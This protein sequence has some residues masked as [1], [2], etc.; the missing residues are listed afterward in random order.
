MVRVPVALRIAAVALL[1]ACS[2]R[3][4]F[5]MT[6]AVPSASERMEPQHG[7]CAVQR[8]AD[9]RPPRLYSVQGRA[10]LLYL[11]LVPWAS[12]PYERLDWSAAVQGSGG[13][14]DAAPTPAYAYVD[15][16]PR[17]IARDLGA[18][19][20]FDEVVYAGDESLEK[21]DYVLTGTLRAT[22]LDVT[23]TSYGLGLAGVLLWPLGIPNGKAT[24]R[25]A[26]DLELRDVADGS[27]V[28][29]HALRGEATRLFTVYT[30][31]I[32]FGQTQLNFSVPAPK[33]SW[34]VDRR[35]M[36]AFHAESLRRAMA[37][38]VPELARALAARD[39]L[40]RSPT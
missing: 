2:V 21:P 22:P 30:P 14:L 17:A 31:A 6:Y 15:L 20:L 12:L 8:F 5:T 28:W 38:A 33:S 29:R 4:T 10:F 25:L 13:A 40:R 27:V 34:P 3:P 24:A 11:P 35:S 26:A 9:A 19:G 18:S 1:A 39:R 7:T 37:E 32:V 36:F 16:V 23:G